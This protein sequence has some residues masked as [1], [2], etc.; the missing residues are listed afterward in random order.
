MMH[1]KH[2][3][4]SANFNFIKNSILMQSSALVRCR[5]TLGHSLARTPNCRARFNQRQN[6]VHTTPQSVTNSALQMPGTPTA[7]FVPFGMSAG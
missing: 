2:L 7:V 4:L 3:C 6:D 1:F 5:P